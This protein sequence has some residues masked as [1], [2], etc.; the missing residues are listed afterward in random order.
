MIYLQ[1]KPSPPLAGFVRSFWYTR[2]PE[3]PH[4]QE[5]VLP[6]G[7]AQMVLSLASNALT[8]CDDNGTMRPQP[9]AILA[10]PRSRYEII[11]TRDLAELVG[12][13]LMPGGLGPWLRLRADAFVNRSI[14]LEDVWGLKDLCDRLREQPSPQRILA[15]LDAL[16]V[17]NLKGRHIERKPLLRAAL[18]DLRSTTVRQTAQSLGVSERRLHQLFSEDAGLS[19]KLWSRVYR[20]QQAVRSLHAGRQLPWEQLALACGYYDQSHFSN[21]FRAFSGIDPTT[22]AAHR[23]LWRNHVAWDTPCA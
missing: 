23:G 5:R 1:M 21:D 3:L 7:F 12:I 17:E 11:H 15:K 8:E 6:N 14:A 18:A 2:A 20:F 13:V 10:G 9:R 22:Y 4:Q 16:L 19:P